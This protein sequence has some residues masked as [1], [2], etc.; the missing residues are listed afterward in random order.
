MLRNYIISRESETESTTSVQL[1][2]K[3]LHIWTLGK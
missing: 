1:V 2:E 3:K